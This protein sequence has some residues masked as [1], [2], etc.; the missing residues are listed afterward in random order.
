MLKT[1]KDANTATKKI[2]SLYELYQLT[3]M[4][5]EA[6]RVTMTTS[7]LIDH[8]FTN[9]PEK[10]QILASFTQVIVIIAWYLQS[11]KFLS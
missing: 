11:E 6:T 9:A 10:I 3:Q 7:S 2:E 5:D 8:I 1:D 4:I